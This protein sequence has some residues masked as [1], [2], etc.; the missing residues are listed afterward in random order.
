MFDPHI[1]TLPDNSK[2][3]WKPA[4]AKALE[5]ALE[6]GKYWKPDIT[7]TGH[8]FMEFAPVSFWNKRR[9]LEMEG[10]RLRH[11]FDY[12]NQLLDKI[13][14]FTKKEVVFQPGN[15]DDWL[16]SYIQERPELEGLINQGELLQFKSRGIKSLEYGKVYRIGKASFSHAFLRRRSSLTK[17]HSAK[18][19]EDYGDN[20]FYGHFH[21]HQTFTQISYGNRQPF[22][23]MGIGCL[24]ELNPGW[25]RS[26]PNNFVNQILFLEMD[27]NGRFTHYAPVLINGKFTYNGKVFGDTRE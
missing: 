9:K 25:Q 18:M 24:S 20:I 10:R 7:I 26:Y 5:T 4:T 11:D 8:D 2:Q 16:E 22:M 6:F 27:K 19:V 23:A 15:H 13:C 1:Q 21:T 12:A 17:Y 14:N 3:G